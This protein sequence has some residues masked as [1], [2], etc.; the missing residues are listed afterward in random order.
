MYYE[1]ICIAYIKH[2]I[3][4]NI[5][6]KCT[7]KI[8]NICVMYLKTDWLKIS[9]KI[10][11]KKTF[12]LSKKDDC[13]IFGKVFYDS[14]FNQESITDILRASLVFNNFKDIYN[15]LPVISEF[16]KDKNNTENGILGF[17]N[18]F[19]LP[20]LSGWRQIIVNFHLSS[21]NPVL[22][23]LQL[24]FAPFWESK[25]ILHDK[26]KVYRLFNVRKKK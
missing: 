25:D 2:I 19:Q 16:C 24:H 6:N 23:E 13:R 17:R 5:I 7:E 11:N 9:D 10:K 15:A 8:V 1:D 18:W 22:C 4:S 14:N 20:M 3:L 21:E 12:W 26:Y